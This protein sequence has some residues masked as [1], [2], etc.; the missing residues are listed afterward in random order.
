MLPRTLIMALAVLVM[1]IIEEA[2][3]RIHRRRRIETRE[4]GIDGINEVS[5]WIF[6]PDD[7]KP[8]AEAAAASPRSD[9][10]SRLLAPGVEP[11]S[12]SP[13]PSAEVVEFH[14]R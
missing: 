1:P 13:L 2:T 10:D 4:A 6:G 12:P 11:S 7:L 14:R 8:D 3:V 5:Y 9:D